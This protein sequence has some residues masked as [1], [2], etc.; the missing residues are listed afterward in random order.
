M[1]EIVPYNLIWE[2]AREWAG[3]TGC[4]LAWDTLKL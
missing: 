3:S 2:A 1:I 4:E